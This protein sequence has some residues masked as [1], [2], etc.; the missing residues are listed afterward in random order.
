MSN[1]KDSIKKVKEK[2]IH[3]ITNSYGI[4]DAYI[5]YKNS[6]STSKEYSLKETD[7]RKLIK[8]VNSLIT[9]DLINTGYFNLPADIGSLRVYKKEVKPV[10]RGGK[11]YYN[12]P[13]D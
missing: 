1:F 4:K 12:A 3:S 8:E 9:E 7:F 11:V 5:Y 6:N 10:I 13:V 2:R